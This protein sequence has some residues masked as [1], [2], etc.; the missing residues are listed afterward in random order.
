[1]RALTWIVIIL[2]VLYGG[3]WF[4][5]ARSAEQA[6]ETAL[7]E[8]GARGIHIAHQGYGISGFP[9][10]FDLTVTEP[11]VDAGGVQWQA[12]FAQVFALS[13]TPWKLIAA[14]PEEQSISFAGQAVDVAS[15]E[16]KASLFM[17]P[18]GALP[19]DR[20]DA[21]IEGASLRSDAG[22]SL[23]FASANASLIAGEGA[24]AQAAFRMLDIVPDQ[25]LMARLN[26][27]L[28]GTVAR[29]DLLADLTLDAALEL[30][31][32]A[33]RLQQVSLTEAN[34]IWGSLTLKAA[35]DLVADPQG[36]AEGTVQLRVEGWQ[37][38]LAA[39]E[40]AGLVPEQFRLPLRSV[41]ENL[42]AQSTETG[43]LQLPLVM[44]N[45]RMMLGPVPLGPAP[46][47][48]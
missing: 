5:G 11:R 32:A 18:R 37:E 46:L 20:F 6:V 23:G 3:Y 30:R 21:V 45:G 29:L 1:M 42:A 36:Q 41:L 34:L 13:Y 12:P 10:R 38:G 25:A 26:G 35:G 7:Q 2:A 47:L 19:L 15:T 27:A 16:M 4:V 17:K 22:W 24:Q 8:A 44:A 31:G 14:L 28:P 48:R 39:L 40:A 43:V 33:P 9:S